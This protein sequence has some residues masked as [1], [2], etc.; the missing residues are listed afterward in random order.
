MDLEVKTN[1]FFDYF[2]NTIL[3]NPDIPETL[4]INMDE[5]PVFLDMVGNSTLDFQGAK[6][7]LINTTGNEKQRITVA[8]AVSSAGTKLKPMII[9]KGAETR[10]ARVIKEFDDRQK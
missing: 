8:L 10:G 9:F 1:A 7:V 3:Q 6:E 2:T 5:T 4:I